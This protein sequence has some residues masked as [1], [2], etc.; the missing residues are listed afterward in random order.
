MTT[1]ADV[2]DLSNSTILNTTAPNGQ[3]A[4]D[5]FLTPLASN[6][7]TTINNSTGYNTVPPQLNDTDPVVSNLISS[8]A[9]SATAYSTFSYSAYVPTATSDT[10]ATS[11][12]DAPTPAWEQPADPVDQAL[13]AAQSYAMQ[14]AIG[15]HMPTVTVELVMVPT[16]VSSAI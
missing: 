12:T 7:T 5:G 4:E 6:E 15:Q 16:Q 10:P 1:A 2:I 8:L 9:A 11:V 13:Q 14:Q 3:D